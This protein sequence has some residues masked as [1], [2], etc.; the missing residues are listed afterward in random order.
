MMRVKV[1]SY[2]PKEMSS[3][4]MPQGFAHLRSPWHRAVEEAAA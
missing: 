2:N 1:K 3:L 4:C